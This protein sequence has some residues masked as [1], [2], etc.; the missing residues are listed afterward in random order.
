GAAGSP[1]GGDHPGPPVSRGGRLL[2]RRGGA[3]AAVAVSPTTIA[4]W[5]LAGEQAH[6]L[7]ELLP[8]LVVARRE[9]GQIPL[10]QGGVSLGEQR[11]RLR[12][13]LV[14]SRLVGA[15]GRLLALRLLGC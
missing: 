11:F 14:G 10:L 6:R 13:Q 8:G 3:F 7:V 12:Q 1:G 5:L 4:R 2:G 9:G 15:L